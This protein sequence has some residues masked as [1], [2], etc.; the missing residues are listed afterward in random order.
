M[1][2]PRQRGLRREVR[3]MLAARSKQ[4]LSLYR[5]GQAIDFVRCP[6]HSALLKGTAP[7]TRP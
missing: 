7:D 5:T 1:T 6:L 3:R 4:L 2:I